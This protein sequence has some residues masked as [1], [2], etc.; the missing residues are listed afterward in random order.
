LT[1]EKIDK[2]EFTELCKRF[3]SELTIK[4]NKKEITY[5]AKLERLNNLVLEKV[6]KSDLNDLNK[7]IENDT[8][9]N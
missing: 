8:K 5:K 3:E 2:S 6:D 7:K 1:S 9:Q 4:Y